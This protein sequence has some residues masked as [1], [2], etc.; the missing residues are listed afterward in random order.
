MSE[1]KF[2]HTHNAGEGFEK[3]DLSPQGVLFFMGGLAVVGVVVYFILVGMYRYLDN[4]DQSHQAPM[5]PM[6]TATNEDRR[7]PTATDTQQ[8]PEPRLEQNERGQLRD[9]VEAQD[10][11]LA[12]YDWVDQKNG[13]VRIPIDQ[14]MALLVQRGLPVLPQGEA[15]RA[16]ASKTKPGATPGKKA[17]SQGK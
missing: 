3:E 11:I 12:S 10:R 7:R 9:V 17:A 15:A 8:F 16:G 4:Y 14:A 1:E 13:I 5:N 6:V 2:N